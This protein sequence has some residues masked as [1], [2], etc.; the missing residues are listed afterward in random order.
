MERNKKLIFLSKILFIYDHWFEKVEGRIILQRNIIS[1]IKLKTLK[2]ER[3]NCNMDKSEESKDISRKN[4][5]NY[6]QQNVLMLLRQLACIQLCFRKRASFCG[7][8]WLLPTYMSPISQ[9]WTVYGTKSKWCHQ[10]FT[11]I[12]KLNGNK[13]HF[14][15]VSAVTMLSSLIKHPLLHVSDAGAWWV[16]TCLVLPRSH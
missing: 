13:I 2:M 12:K 4:F 14:S 8:Y 10:F 15:A 6:M 11:I 1:S 16:V 3:Y 9:H 5:L 7:F